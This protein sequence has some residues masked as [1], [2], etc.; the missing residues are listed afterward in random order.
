MSCDGVDGI[1]ACLELVLESAGWGNH[2]PIQIG[3]TSG[4]DI[5]LVQADP[6]S[7]GLELAV[8]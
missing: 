1:I 2:P 7:D 5:D 4:K 6:C 3:L 8:L